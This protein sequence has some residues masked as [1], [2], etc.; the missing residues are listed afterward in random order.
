M[1][2]TLWLGLSLVV[3][4][5]KDKGAGDDDDDDTTTLPY[6]FDC[7]VSERYDLADPFDAIEGIEHD[8]ETRPEYIDSVPT[9]TSFF[10]GEF[11]YDD[12]G[13][14]HGQEHWILYANPRWVELG[15]HDCEVVYDV[16]GAATPAGGDDVTLELSAVLNAPGTT[17]D[18]IVN[19]AGE[20]F[21]DFV[22]PT[23]TVSYDVAVVGSEA[24]FFF[25]GGSEL[26]RGEANANH[27]NYVTDVQCKLF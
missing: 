9:A 24:T 22:D 21:M 5:N 6:T 12:C 4:C 10:V 27:S 18:D 16:D 13:N 8:C 15:G 25:T 23:F 19:G 26:G 20:Y 3:A 17:C 11:H 14:L 7:P 1:R 2:A